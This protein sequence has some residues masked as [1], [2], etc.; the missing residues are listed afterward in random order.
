MSRLQSFIQFFFFGNYFYGTCAVALT[1]E[2][3][4]QQRFP[5][6]EII[7]FIVLFIASVIYYTK[8][9]Q[10]ETSNIH[11]V[12]LR[13]EWYGKHKKFIKI[14]Q[15]LMLALLIF[16][17][18]NF[19]FHYWKAL[20]AMP[21]YQLILLGVFPMAGSLYYGID[22]NSTGGIN[23]RDIG[24]IKPFVIGFT[25]A[26]LVN[27][28]P[29]LY[30]CIVHQQNHH[31]AVTDVL[32]FIKNFMFISVLCILFDIK[33]YA[34]DANMQLKTFVV[35]VG[36][37]KTIFWIIIPLVL[38]GFASFILFALSH[39]FSAIKIL[40]NT[41]PFLLLLFVSYSLKR[42]RSIL[43]YLILIDGLMLIKAICGSIAMLYG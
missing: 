43:F 29:I 17:S 19:L 35:R 4:L 15:C 16:W 28:Y 2:A 18:A 6:N 31:F 10:S 41:L 22:S 25:W 32:L 13:S 1:I 27:I 8:A 20:W 14:S 24:W 37:R 30:Y 36:L 3:T 33:D 34:S 7:Y 5:I 26:G 39:Q 40:L 12:N 21:V 23:L 11:P 9:Y 42:R 38:I